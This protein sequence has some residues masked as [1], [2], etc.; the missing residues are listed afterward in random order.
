MTNFDLTIGY[1]FPEK[2]LGEVSSCSQDVF[3]VFTVLMIVAFVFIYFCSIVSLLGLLF[4]SAS[5]FVC[6][7]CIVDKR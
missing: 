5:L 4:L 1:K 6:N 2:L 7:V 3:T